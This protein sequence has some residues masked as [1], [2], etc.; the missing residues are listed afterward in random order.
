MDLSFLSQVF[1][2][3]II[4]II[5]VIIVQVLRIMSREVK[6]STPGNAG[7]LGWSIKVLYSA[8][9]AG[10]QEGNEIPISNKITIGRS[11]QNNLVLPASS[12]SSFHARI[13]YSDGRY[14]L[15]DLNSTNGTYVN[16]VIVNKRIL[17]PG[18]EIRISNTAFTVVD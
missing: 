13:T 4:I 5:F 14:T 15:E 11:P 17:Q 3:L 18:D 16:G 8:D 1:K 12:V 10:F 7:N 9:N 6:K 2:F